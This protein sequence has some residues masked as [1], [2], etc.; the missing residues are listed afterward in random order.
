MADRILQTRG[1]C[2]TIL[3]AVN[4]LSSFLDLRYFED[5]TSTLNAKYGVNAN[6]SPITTPQLRY[7]GCGV[8]GFKNTDM[9]QGSRRYDPACS[10]M[11]LYMPIPIRCVPVENDLN[12]TERAKY[13][14]RVV[15]N[16]PNGKF[17]CYYLKLVTADPS[18]VEV[19]VKDANGTETPYVLDPGNL[20]PSPMD[21]EVGGIVD[22]SEGRI[23]VRATLS[24]ELYADEI[25][26]AVNNLYNGDIDVYGHISEYGFYS[27]CEVDVDE[28]ENIVTSGGV[29]KEAIYV[30][31]AKKMCSKGTD[32]VES[33]AFIVPQIRMEY[34]DILND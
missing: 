34:A 17:A 6:V 26:E 11:D 29:N 25:L 5:L 31:L 20:N 18:T 30:Q 24:C 14:M 16:T 3:A 22:A 27:G 12:A 1:T 33:G 23:I 15:Q 7:F 13:R 2:T 21:P 19:V 10:E 4:Q 8:K 9:N 28:N 32:L